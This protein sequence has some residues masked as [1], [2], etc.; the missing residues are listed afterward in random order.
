[1][2]TRVS[3]LITRRLG[4]IWHICMG[5]FYPLEQKPV[6]G[7]ANDAEFN[8]VFLRKETA[9]AELRLWYSSFESMMKKGIIPETVGTL[10][11]K[12][13]FKV[14]VMTLETT[15][16]TKFIDT[17]EMWDVVDLS[18]KVLI[19]LQSGSTPKFALDVG[20]VIPLYLVGI[21]CSV[22]SVRR[23]AIEL[24]LTYPRRE[25]LWDSVVAGNVV[26]WILDVESVYE[27]RARGRIP[28]WARINS[29]TMTVDSW[30][31]SMELA[32]FQQ[33]SE[34]DRTMREVKRTLTF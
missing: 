33:T 15:L 20:V 7:E 4:D 23:E 31:R 1:M 5:L 2:L 34:K 24:L 8:D 32:G 21:K 10:M 27:D 28:N 16:H 3:R 22:T 25:G 19:G 18:R 6:E 26:Q 14:A 13:H 9:L 29:V 11:L 17:P 30:D 12:M